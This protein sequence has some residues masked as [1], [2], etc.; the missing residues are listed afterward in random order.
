MLAAV[1]DGTDL[2]LEERPKPKINSEEALVKVKAATICQTDLRIL[3][4]GHKKISE[5]ESAVLGHEFTGEIVEVGEN[6][7]QLEVGQDIVIAPNIGC[8]KCEQCLTGNHHRCPDFRAVGISIDG[9][10]EEF[11]KVPA[12]AIERGNVVPLPEGIDPNEAAITEPLSTCYNALTACDIGVGDFVLVI[13]A[14]PMGLFNMLMAKYAGASKLIVSEVVEERKEKAK[15]FGA[16]IILDPT[17]APL[18]EQVKEVTRGRGV[19]VSIVA[20]PVSQA[21]LQAIK[22]TAIEGKVN[23]FATLPKDQELKEFP[24]NYLHYNQVYVTGTSGASRSHFVKT[25]DIIASGRLPLS[26]VVTH[27]YPLEEIDKAIEKA[28]ENDSLKV[29][30]RP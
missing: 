23:F 3:N 4:E 30:V 28:K 26:K 27:E 7:D 13:G 10:F 5:G 22:S 12:E 8:G 9:G 11:F 20:A 19:D 15:E 24:S 29:L 1:Y 6:V 18:E 16:D 2:K 25:L 21:Q 14:G 17:E